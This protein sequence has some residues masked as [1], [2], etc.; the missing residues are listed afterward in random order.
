LNFNLEELGWNE[1][2]AN[3][4]QPYLENGF[5][6]GRISAEH[7]NRF[8]VYTEIGEI[9]AAVSGK[10]RYSALNRSDFPAVGDW[11]VLDNVENAPSDF[12]SQIAIIHAVLPRKS[13]FSRKAAGKA[14]DEQIISTNIDMVFLVNALNY[15]F[16]LR[17]LERYLTLAWESGANPIIILSKSDLCENAAQ[18]VR[19]VEAAAP[20]VPIHPISCLTHEGIDE[21]KQYFKPGQTV[22]LLG[23]SGAGKSTLVN[24]LF[25]IE[26]QKTNEVREADSRGRHTTTSRELFL[27]P[28]GG[29]LIDTPGMREL[30]LYGSGD[31]LFD[32]FEDIYEYARHCRFSDC[33]HQ[34]EPGCKIQ[35]ALADGS[36]DVER[37]E[38][39]RKL[40][41]EM[42]YISRKENLQEALEE[43]KKW[44]KINKELKE[45]YRT[46][47]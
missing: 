16:N 42:S 2:F 44:K 4:F 9:W 22:A 23:S 12:E 21:L 34:T 32:A 14:S 5:R 8:Q 45:H 11:V 27:L 29:L 33:Q 38:S 37:Y 28:Q 26:V 10:M 43:K 13:K 19:E 47:R 31:G 3:S 36:L 24:R 7:K 18:R 15:D 20:G 46:Q 40:Q 1:T 41:R 35:E 25:G 39:F 6:V 30:Q 17:R